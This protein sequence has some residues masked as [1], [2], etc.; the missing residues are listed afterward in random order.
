MSLL[1]TTDAGGPD[2]INRTFGS[3]LI[4]RCAN[5]QCSS[6]WLH[7]F[8]NR[9]VPIFEGGWTCSPEC[10][11]ACVLSAVRRELNGRSS[12]RR[13]HQHRIPLGLLMLEKGWI[14]QEQL[15][16]ALEAQNSHREARFGEWLIKQHVVD[17]SMVTRAL[18]LQWGCPVL[19]PDLHT[20]PTLAAIMPRL[21]I[22]VTGALPLRVAANRILYLGFE[23]SLDPVLALALERITGL[24]VE[25]GIVP[26]YAFRQTLQ[27]TLE[28]KFA[29]SQLAQA[30]S[31]SAASHLMAKAV[32]RAQPLE[33]RLVR[34][35]NFLWMRL[36]LS[37]SLTSPAEISSVND[38]ICIL[39]NS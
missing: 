29:H 16:A 26:S 30:A 22:E 28:L 31:V 11:E 14:S 12:V 18:G 33:A 2:T 6:G 36:I 5:P 21:L 24:R 10:T 1:E 19:L 8:R 37:H 23:Q 20:R 34:V 13:T 27:H 15:R 9:S 4:D 7:I 39:K 17:E 35:H 32:E 25:S 3:H 38:V